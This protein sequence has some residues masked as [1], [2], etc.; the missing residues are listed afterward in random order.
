MF[1][2]EWLVRLEAVDPAD[3]NKTFDVQL[4]A[5]ERDVIA[6][7]GTPGRRNPVPALL[8]VAVARRRNGL[9]EVVLPQPG[10]PVGHSAFFDER[11]LEE[12]GR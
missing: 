7:R 8:R 3:P 11:V 5:D 10:Q 12:A 2:G 6:V 4:F 9:A 1:K